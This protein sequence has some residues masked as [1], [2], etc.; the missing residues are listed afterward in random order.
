[1]K[2]VPRPATILSIVA[3]VCVAAS[4]LA[5]LAWR[6]SFPDPSPAPVVNSALAEARGWS[7]ATL[8]VAIPLAVIAFARQAHEGSQQ[9]CVG[10]VPL[11]RLRPH[12]GELALESPAAG[13]LRKQGSKRRVGSL[14]LL[15]RGSLGIRA[16]L[17]FDRSLKDLGDI[18]LLDSSL[19]G[20]CNDGERLGSR[21][22]PERRLLRHLPGVCGGRSEQ[23]AG[24][25]LA[26]HGPCR[27]HRRS[28]ST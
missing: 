11:D 2:P 26:G 18:W 3:V 17:A 7:A 20:V 25:S 5:T 22:R 23:S 15:A 12:H 13:D 4:S 27:L 14:A 10:D 6:G 8:L 19:E 1:M 28:V 9:P 21:D 24:V 16:P